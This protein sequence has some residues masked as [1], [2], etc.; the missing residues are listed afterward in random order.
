MRAG[1]HQIIVIGAGGHARPVVETLLLTGHRIAGL[2]DDDTSRAPVLGHA[3]IGGLDQLPRLR[4]AGIDGA[5]IAIG[6]NA[7]RLALGDRLRGLGYTLPILAHP[8]AVIS[9]HASIA[10]GAQILARAVVGPEARI[11]RL[12]L[13]N[14]GAII[15]HECTVDEGAHIAPGA[16]LC[17]QVRIGARS[18]VGAGS[19]T[20]AGRHIGPDAT[21]AAGAA[22]TT[23]VAAGARVGG[24][25][26]RG[27]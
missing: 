16:I 23:D 20:I 24:V 2:V 17:G 26:A 22:V 12:C 9:P 27:L 4:A 13:I 21:I 18:L 11:G 19:T 14:T 3:I 6:H 10:E 5:A 15:D 7:T 8:T 25:P 1:E